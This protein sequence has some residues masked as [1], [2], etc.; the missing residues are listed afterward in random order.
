MTEKQVNIVRSRVQREAVKFVEDHNGRSLLGMATGSG[1]SKIP[2]MYAKKKKNKVKTIALIV[3]T[4]RLRDEGWH[5]EFKKWDAEDMWINVTRL[6][7]ASASK[8][9]G[10]SFD[11][12]IL[13]ECHN[14]TEL[15]SEFFRDNNCRDIIGLTATIPKDFEKFYL[16]QTIGLTAVYKVTLDQAVKM[17]FV[18]PYR[19]TVGYVQ[20][21]N[22]NKIIKAGSK[23]KPFYQTEY[24]NYI[25][26]HNQISRMEFEGNT[27]STRYKAFVLK[28]MRAIYN[29][30]SKANI[31]RMALGQL[32]SDDRVLIFC[33]TVEQAEKISEYT[34]HSKDKK[35]SKEN[36][37]KFINKEINEI[38]CVK[39]LN[40]GENLPDLDKAII[41]Q[42][43]SQEKDLVQRIG[44]LIRYRPGHKAHILILVAKNTQD[45][46]WLASALENIDKSIIDFKYFE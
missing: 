18:S 29:L 23:E 5:E 31:A 13:D 17:G 36:L 27:Q 30:E 46:V 8:I 44:R 38:S 42:L 11:L 21:D 15:N 19:I 39:R 33:G 25:Y 4:E 1:K 10:E 6:C 41:V 28:R 20:L 32:D 16:L 14:I 9:K 7:Y 2:I 3:P 24:A 40:E 43:N 37:K 26:L 34:Y 35:K 12:V 45:E 22:K